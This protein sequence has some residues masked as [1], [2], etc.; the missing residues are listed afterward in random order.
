[1]MK[2]VKQRRQPQK[3]KKAKTHNN[4]QQ[5]NNQSSNKK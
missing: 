4:K 2:E 1:M 3:L 5:F